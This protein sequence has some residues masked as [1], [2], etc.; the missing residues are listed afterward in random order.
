MLKKNQAVI[1]KKSAA[2]V[3]EIEDEKFAIKYC[4][5]PATPG[6]KPA[7]YE[8]QKVREKDVVPLPSENVSLEKILSFGD[9]S[10]KEKILEAYEL[11][12]S[13][14]ESAGK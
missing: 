9:D 6:G 1:Y 8:N 13:D 11:L 2:V 5:S 14:E 12:I 3:T 10:A 7:K 4:V